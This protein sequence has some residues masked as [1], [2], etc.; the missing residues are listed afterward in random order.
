MSEKAASTH[1]RILDHGLAIVSERGLAG[2]TLGLLAE[3]SGLSKSGLFAHFRSKE[4]LQIAL[5]R[6]AEEALQ[7]EVA[8]PTMGA[9]PGLPRLRVLMDRWLGWA[10]RSG[11]PGGCPMTAAAFEFDDADGPVREYLVESQRVWSGV[12]RGIV[13]EAVTLGHLRGDV[14]ITQ[15]AWQLNGIYLM[16]HAAHR[17]LRDPDADARAHAAFAALVAAHANGTESA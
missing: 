17:L 6:A 12:L 5:L 8:V 13:E 16:H 7:R 1:Q 3:R 2:V 9:A 11:L 14:D 10:A 15:F 4:E